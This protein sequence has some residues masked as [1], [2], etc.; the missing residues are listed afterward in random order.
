MKNKRTIQNLIKRQEL[1]YIKKLN[2]L[3]G[4]FSDTL[5]AKID[6]VKY[7]DLPT[8]IATCNIDCGGQHNISNCAICK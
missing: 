2:C 6:T 5:S 7:P 8:N 4:G 3:K 1:K